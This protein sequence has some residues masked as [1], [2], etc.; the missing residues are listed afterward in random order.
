MLTVSFG[1]FRA[2]SSLSGWKVRLASKSDEAF[3][4]KGGLAAQ[5]GATKSIF[6]QN[7]EPWCC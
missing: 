4:E 5:I 1:L 3:I 7:T 6:W 2:A